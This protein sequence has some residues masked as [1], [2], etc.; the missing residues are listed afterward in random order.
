VLGRGAG[1]PD[2]PYPYMPGF[3]RSYS[4]AE[5]A[6]VANYVTARFGSRPSRVT[7]VDVANLR[8]QH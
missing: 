5:I 8:R 2:T 3:G 6:A 7:P 1:K 4:D